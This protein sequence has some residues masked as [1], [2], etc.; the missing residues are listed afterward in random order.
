[1]TSLEIFGFNYTDDI[2]KWG[3]GQLNS[4]NFINDG[5][6]SKATLL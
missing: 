5:G 4:S 2:I 3:M 6:C 1:M